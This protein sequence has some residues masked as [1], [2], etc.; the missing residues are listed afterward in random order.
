MTIEECYQLLGGNFAEVMT[1]LPSVKL[2]EKFAVKFLGDDSYDTLVREMAAGNR[3][4]AFR[5]AHTLKGV[6]ANMSF[7]RLFQ[8]ASLLTEELRG[9]GTAIPDHALA[10]LEDV[11]RDYDLTANTIRSY[12]AGA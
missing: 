1:R 2:V 3:Q 7:T 11:K 8:S 10:L 4:S 12:A 9:D 5:A 6:C